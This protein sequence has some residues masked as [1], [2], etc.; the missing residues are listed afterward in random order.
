M[1]NQNTN[2]KSRGSKG[3][4]M[5]IIRVIVREVFVVSLVTYFLFLV[6][7]SLLPGFVTRYFSLSIL[8]FLAVVSYLVIMLFFWKEP[9]KLRRAF[10]AFSQTQLVVTWVLAILF[11]FA[12]GGIVFLQTRTLGIF[13][14]LLAGI[15]GLI[16]FFFVSPLLR[17]SDDAE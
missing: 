4:S 5:T 14:V 9:G 16:I 7:E 12:G 17:D 8:L 11:G 3:T 13:S 15:T 10:P 1:G 2:M 6:I